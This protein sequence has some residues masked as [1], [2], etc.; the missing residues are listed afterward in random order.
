MILVGSALAS[1]LLISLPSQATPATDLGLSSHFGSGLL[2]ARRGADD[3]PNHDVG[4]DRGRGRGGRGHSEDSSFDVN[5]LARRGADDG[6]N[7]DVGD[8]HGRGRGGRGDRGG[9]G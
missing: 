4:D 9:R 2:I 1:S 8:D 5:Q 6:P 3:G 7:H